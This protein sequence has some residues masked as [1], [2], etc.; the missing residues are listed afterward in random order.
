MAFGLFLEL[1]GIIQPEGR[2]PE[3]IDGRLMEWYRAS[4]ARSCVNCRLSGTGVSLTGARNNLSKIKTSTGRGAKASLPARPLA[5]AIHGLSKLSVNDIGECLVG[6]RPKRGPDLKMG[7]SAGLQ[8]ESQKAGLRHRVVRELGNLQ[9]FADEPLGIR[10]RHAPEARER[11]LP[12]DTLLRLIVQR[13]KNAKAGLEE[14]GSRV[15]IESLS[16]RREKNPGG[17]GSLGVLGQGNSGDEQAALLNSVFTQ[18]HEGRVT[19]GTTVA[20][21]SPEVRPA[22][23]VRNQLFRDGGLGLGHR[24]LL[25]FENRNLEAGASRQK[26]I[27]CLPDSGELVGK[28]IVILLV[29]LN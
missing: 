1:S 17:A 28:Q 2:R 19:E 14:F 26:T 15:S 11:L 7:L 12:E 16:E 29:L 3:G 27:S 20:L 22:G 8:F 4:N 21:N 6:L 23:S 25:G 24:S 18:T 10:L 9:A 5:S 13:M